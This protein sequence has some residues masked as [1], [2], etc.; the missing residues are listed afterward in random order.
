M[1]R[2]RW[3]LKDVVRHDQCEARI[4]G[5]AGDHVAI[6]YLEGSMGGQ[7]V[8]VPMGECQ[9]ERSGPEKFLVDDPRLKRVIRVWDRAPSGFRNEC[10]LMAA[11]WEEA[12]EAIDESER[13]WRE[14]RRLREDMEEDADEDA[15]EDEIP[16]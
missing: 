6:R 5:I 9:W 3:Q 8:T 16:W 2:R 10:D 7:T 4:V 1:R 14:A 15:E 13:G 11:Q 12:F